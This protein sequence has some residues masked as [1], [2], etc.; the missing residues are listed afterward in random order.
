MKQLVSV[1]GFFMA[2][3][4]SSFFLSTIAVSKDLQDKPEQMGEEMEAT[5]GRETMDVS[6]GRM[7]YAMSCIHCHGAEGKG[8]GAASIYIGPYSHPRPNDFTRGIFKFRSTESGELPMLTDLMRTIR[9]GI[10]GYMPSFR[11]L[12]EKKIRQVALYVSTAFIREELPTESAITYVQHVGPYTYSVESV[13]RG[14]RLYGEMKCAE[15]HGEDGRGAGTSLRDERGLPI[16]PVDLTRHETFG[17]GT[18]HEDIY[19][20]IMTGLDGTPM[21]GYS[22]LFKGREES[23]WDL[24]HFILSLQGR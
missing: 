3:I 19:R 12:G 2:A 23:A 14:K 11:N 22:D 4:A 20:T 17:N 16:K 15:C 1:F 10:P 13:R 5:P 18:S 21:P 6:V 7:I 8:D 24:V 9:K